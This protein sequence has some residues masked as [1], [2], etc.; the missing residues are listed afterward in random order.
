M[1]IRLT[2][3]GYGVAALVGGVGGV[4]EVLRGTVG[5]VVKETAVKQD[6]ERNEEVIRSAMRAVYALAMVIFFFF[7]FL[8]LIILFSFLFFSFYLFFMFSLSH[9]IPQVP[10]IEKNP[11]FREFLQ[12]IKNGP[13]REKFESVQRE[14]SEGGGGGSSLNDSMDYITY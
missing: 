12:M 8:I 9:S 5:R 14:R 4:V 10:H 3:T 2:E 1:V 6:V 13:L 11:R 7:F